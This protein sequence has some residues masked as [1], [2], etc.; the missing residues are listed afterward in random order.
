MAL[1]DVILVNVLAD[2]APTVMFP[3]SITLYEGTTR[4]VTGVVNS[5]RPV[6]DSFTVEIYD[7]YIDWLNRQNRLTSGTVPT[8]EI[9]SNTPL[10]TTSDTRAEITLNVTAPLLSGQQN[11]VYWCRIRYAITDDGDRNSFGEQSTFYISVLQGIVASVSIAA[12]HPVYE[13]AD[14]ELS[15]NLGLGSPIA[16]EVRHSWHNSLSDAMSGDDPVTAGRPVVTNSWTRELL[17]AEAETYQFDRARTGTLS[18]RTPAVTE[19]Q[20]F[21]G[22]LEVLQTSQGDNTERV[23]D[24]AAYTLVIEN[25]QVTSAM[26]GNHTAIEGSPIAIA[27]MYVGGAPR[28]DSWGIRFASSLENA[29]NGVYLGSNDDLNPHTIAIVPHRPNGGA[30][31]RRAEVQMTLPY[32]D[33]D[34]VIWADFRINAVNPQTND[35]V[36]THVYFMITILNRVRAHI[37]FAEMI[38]LDERGT[39]MLMG[40]YTRG[41]P[42]ATAIGVSVHPSFDDAANNRNRLSGTLAEGVPEVTISPTT[43]D[44]SGLPT[45]RKTV[46]LTFVAPDED[47]NEDYGLLVYITQDVFAPDP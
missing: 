34:E 24:S 27:F 37:E 4:S 12:T 28:P 45:D 47:A 25:N 8:V 10:P 46:T 2:K 11:K 18:M 43:P 15:Y 17:Q 22:R 41:I 39:K 9:D 19:R 26:I 44:T 35:P 14:I 5:G 38:S 42:A 6:A 31:T 29:Q 23:V 16:S 20:M 13:N 7:T 40:W 30:L 33:Q 32:V 1:S 36:V 3:V 21:Y